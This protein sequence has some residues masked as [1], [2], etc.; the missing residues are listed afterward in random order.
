MSNYP[1]V[2]LCTSPQRRLVVSLAAFPSANSLCGVQPSFLRKNEKEWREIALFLAAGRVA[3]RRDA[4]A[5]TGQ[6]QRRTVGDC[7]A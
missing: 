3:P 5:L 6:A 1:I 4:L 7:A 2:P